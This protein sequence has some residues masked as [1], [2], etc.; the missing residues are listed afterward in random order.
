[1]VA[2]APFRA[3][4][5]QRQYVKDVASYP[6]DVI[7]SR[8]ARLLVRDNARS[9]LQIEKSEIYSPDNMAVCEEIYER[10][11]ANLFEFLREGTLFQDETP[12]FYIYRQ[13]MNGH[14][15]YGLVGCVNAADYESGIIKRHELTRR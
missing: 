2:L 15:Q 6:Y 11:R 1:M 4:R 8:E 10:A 9:F 5:P 7:D 12:L 13:G 14:L 3:V